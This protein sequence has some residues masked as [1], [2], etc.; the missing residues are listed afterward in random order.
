MCH[1]GG[2]T[3][4]VVLR[5]P[6]SVLRQAS[7]KWHSNRETNVHWSFSE[8]KL[9]RLK[10]A[11]YELCRAQKILKPKFVSLRT[12]IWGFKER[13]IRILSNIKNS[14]ERINITQSN[15]MQLSMYQRLPSWPLQPS[16]LG[17]TIPL[18][19]KRIKHSLTCHRSTFSIMVK[20]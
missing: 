20:V 14:C 17:S 16:Y 2:E 7:F 18:R 10:Y 6:V 3:L 15:R 5:A 13:L 1:C 8:Y 9:H 19:T 11:I 12:E 4:R